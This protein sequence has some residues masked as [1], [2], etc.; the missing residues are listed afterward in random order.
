MI[1]NMYTFYYM[2]RIKKYVSYARRPSRP[3]SYF[4]NTTA[5]DRKT[6]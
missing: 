4:T 2:N 6:D 3:K 1:T 5:S